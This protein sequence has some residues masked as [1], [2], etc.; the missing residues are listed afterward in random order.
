MKYLLIFL[1][2]TNLINA[3]EFNDKLSII[4]SVLQNNLYGNKGNKY[5]NLKYNINKY[6]EKHNINTKLKLPNIAKKIINYSNCNQILTNNG[7]FSTCYDYNLKSPKAIYS[8]VNG[9]LVDRRMV[10]NNR[11]YEDKNIPKKYRSTYYDYKG[12]DRGHAGVSNASFDY[13]KSSQNST[14]V[15]SQIVAQKPNTNRKSYLKIENRTRQLSKRYGK[16]QVLTIIHYGIN[17]KRIGKNNIAVPNSF[18]K[19]LFNQEKRIQECYH[20]KND[21]KVYSLMQMKVSCKS[22]FNYY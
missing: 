12:Y 9:L 2:L 13:S 4:V 22:I 18:S 15:L 3:D 10:S 17:P 5:E 16:I 1:L 6:N 7:L 19:M 8:E 21:N 11:F 20:V 14:Y